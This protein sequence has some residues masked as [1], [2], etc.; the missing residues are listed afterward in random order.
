MNGSLSLKHTLFSLSEAWT[1]VWK[2]GTVLYIYILG[3]GNWWND[4]NKAAWSRG[5]KGF[6]FISNDGPATE[7]LTT[8]LPD[9]DYCNVAQ[10]IDCFTYLHHERL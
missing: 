3:A 9:G 2:C 4:G 8:G 6:V 1:E 5:N 7:T 10:V